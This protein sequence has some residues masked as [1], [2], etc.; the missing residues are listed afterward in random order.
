MI[1]KEKLNKYID[2]EIL[3]LE[4]KR[5]DLFPPHCEETNISIK[6]GDTLMGH[7]L[8]LRYLAGKIFSGEFDA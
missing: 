3:R 5:D 7:V 2:K 1:D 4:R 8:S 6:M